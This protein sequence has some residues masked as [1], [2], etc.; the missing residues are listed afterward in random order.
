[1]RLDRRTLLRGMGGIA[2]GL[3]ALEAMGLGGKAEAATATR[4]V[5]SYGGLSLTRGSLNADELVPTVVGRN[6]DVRRAL[7]PVADLGLRD[8]VSVVSGLLLP[9]SR[10]DTEPVPPGGRSRFFHFN[11]VGPQTSGATGTS[12]RG[13]GRPRGPSADQLVAGV[14]AGN[15]PQKVLAY[16]VQAASGSADAGRL[17]WYRNGSG[18]LVPQDPIASPRLAYQSL[19]S[20]FTAPTPGGTPDTSKLQQVLAQRRSVLDFVGGEAN[21][22]MTRLGQA[23]RARMQLHLTQLRDL[24]QRLATLPTLPTGTSCK[25]P[26]APG[27]D[28]AVGGEFGYSDEETRADILSDLIAMAF[29]CNLSRVASYMITDWKCYLNMKIPTGFSGD[30]HSLTHGSYPLSMVSDAVAWMVKQWAKLIVKLKA[31][32]ETDGG[33]ILDRT[34]LVLLFEGGWGQDPEAGG[35]SPHSTENMVALIAGRAGGLR[36]GQHVRAAGKH[37]AQV[38]LSAMNAVGVTADSLGDVH[39]NIPQLF[40]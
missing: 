36:S 12:G 26:T 18:T 17:S 14:I 30:M 38:V 31:L 19:F 3:P 40:Q 22:L 27:T 39:G 33:T 35:R 4:F 15:T 23:D 6:Y 20:G 13:G 24:E 5:L 2:L 21:R 16:R 11:T 28:P 37:P 10:S 34:A 32:R 25:Q 7:Q 29:A 9:W 8:D 1:M